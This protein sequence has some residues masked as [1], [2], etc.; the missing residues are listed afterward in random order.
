MREGIQKTKRKYGTFLLQQQRIGVTGLEY[1]SLTT[2]IELK[3]LI[4]QIKT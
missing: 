2:I 3:I 1:I 4:D